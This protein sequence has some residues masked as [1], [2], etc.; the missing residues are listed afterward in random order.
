MIIDAMWRKT[1]SDSDYQLLL[2]T[3]DTMML[4]IDHCN[5]DNADELI[6]DL[7]LL[8]EIAICKRFN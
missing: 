3:L 2:N 7:A 6:D 1:T 5:P 4:T 8:K